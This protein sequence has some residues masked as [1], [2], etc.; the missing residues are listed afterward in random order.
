MVLLVTHLSP[1]WVVGNARVD[2]MPMSDDYFHTRVM[3]AF[4]RSN[5]TLPMAMIGG[6]VPLAVVFHSSVCLINF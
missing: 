6:C 3:H 2:Y 5:N 4:I 1:A